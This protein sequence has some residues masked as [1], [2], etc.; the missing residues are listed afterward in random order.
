MPGSPNNSFSAPAVHGNRG[1]KAYRPIGVKSPREARAYRERKLAKGVEPVGLCRHCGHSQA[2]HF[3]VDGE[4]ICAM[5]HAAVQDGTARN[6][7]CEFEE[8][9]K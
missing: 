9:E 3:T 2:P 1:K 7:L 6:Y 8:D 4:K 5:C